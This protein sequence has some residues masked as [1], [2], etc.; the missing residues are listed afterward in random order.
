M[1]LYC[2]CQITGDVPDAARDSGGFGPQDN[3][4]FL[5]P[6]RYGVMREKG[7]FRSVI[8]DKPMIC[9]KAGVRQEITGERH[10]PNLWDNTKE[11][12]DTDLEKRKNAKRH[13]PDVDFYECP[14]CR[15][16]VMVG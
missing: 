2:M 5:A 1:K 14:V 11:A 15:A 8:L 6:N 10:L 7:S 12:F 4:V 13:Y 9:V 16:Q 3:Q